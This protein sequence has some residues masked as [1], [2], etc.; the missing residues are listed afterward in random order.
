MVIV[1]P[2]AKRGGLD[3]NNATFASILAYTEHNFGLKP[4]AAN[5]RNAYNYAKAFNYHQTPLNGVALKT[6][7]IPRSS[8]QYLRTHPSPDD[9]DT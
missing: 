4:L 1:S 8:L 9:D 7:P 3:S 2:Y 6:R 5:D